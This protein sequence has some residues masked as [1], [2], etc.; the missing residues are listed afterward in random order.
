MKTH[1]RGRL[2][3]KEN[4]RLQIQQSGFAYRL[5]CGRWIFLS[6]RGKLIMPDTD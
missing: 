1:S 6:R 2:V 3:Q 5:V 4:V